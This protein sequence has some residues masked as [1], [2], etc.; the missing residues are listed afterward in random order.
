MGVRLRPITAEEFPAWRAAFGRSYAAGIAEHA[1]MSEADA[2]RKADD[3]FARLMADGYETAGMHMLVIE[4]AAGETVGRICYSVGPDP[5]GN[6]RVFLFEIFVDGG[7]RGRGYGRAAMLALEE[8]TRRHG[9]DRIAL[10]VFGGNEVARGLYRSLGYVE[11][12]VLMSK[13]L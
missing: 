5:A 13:S 7:A 8:E 12:A 1:G 2:A 3:D 6:D 9:L 11:R 4:D 10:N